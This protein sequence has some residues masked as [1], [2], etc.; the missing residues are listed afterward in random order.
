MK[1]IPSVEINHVVYREKSLVHFPDNTFGTIL[2]LTNQDVTICLNGEN[3]PDIIPMAVFLDEVQ[4][5]QLLDRAEQ[6]LS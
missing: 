6:K 4:E 5:R 1:S 2:A 3:T